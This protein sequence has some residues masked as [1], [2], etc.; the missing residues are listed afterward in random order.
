MARIVDAWRVLSPENRDYDS[1]VQAA[2]AFAVGVDIDDVVGVEYGTH[3]RNAQ[4]VYNV[5]FNDGTE[6]IVFGSADG[7]RFVAEGGSY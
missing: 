2:A 7:T 4:L 1:V 5:I 6:M 3:P